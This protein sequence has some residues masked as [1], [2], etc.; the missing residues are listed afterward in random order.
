MQWKLNVLYFALIF[1]IIIQLDIF[2]NLILNSDF[3]NYYFTLRHTV[4]RGR[5]VPS[6]NKLAL[7]EDNIYW[8]DNTR[9]G[10]IRAHQSK[11]A[12]SIKVI[13]QNRNVSEKPLGIKAYHR[14]RQPPGK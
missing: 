13:Y 14:T 2:L 11:G 1:K 6:A 9:Q 4:L 5:S 8:T 12:E 7:F 3:Q 10:V